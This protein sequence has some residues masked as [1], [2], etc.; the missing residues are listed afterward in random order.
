M[1]EFKVVESVSPF[2]R[3]AA[4]M[5]SR[6]ADPSIHGVL[7]VDAER[8]LAFLDAHAREH[9]VKLTIT[10]LVTRAV[11]LALRAQPD[12]NTQVRFWGRIEQRQTVDLFVTV[13]TDGGKDLSGARLERV[14]ERSLVAIAR[15]LAERA[16][17]IRGGKD[18]DYQ[19]S[20]SV[21]SRLPWWLGST[22]TRV[23]DLLVNELHVDL[24]KQG[25]P[26]D[27]FGAAMITSVG[28][29]GID[30]AFAPLLPMARCPILILLPE[31]RPRPWVVGD[32]V[33]VRPVLRL[34]ATFDHRIVDGAAAGR[35]ART[36]TSLF[37]D[38]QQLA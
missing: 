26:R 34:C 12:L 20:R 7:D 27:P 1:T 11:A 33:E 14:D 38:P 36:L 5:W 22:A 6:P 17:K 35:F 28:M 3:M 2:R 29:F 37:S 21:F 4:G 13:A 24:A 10:H 16:G 15:E 23:S 18:K 25:L 19:K 8:P 9:A 32:R 31:V 30:T